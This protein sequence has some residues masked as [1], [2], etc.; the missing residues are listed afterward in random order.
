MGLTCT[1]P[2]AQQPHLLPRPRPRSFF[3]LYWSSFVIWTNSS[4][5]N[6]ASIGCGDDA[7]SGTTGGVHDTSIG[8]IEVSSTGGGLMLV[9]G[10]S[11]RTDVCLVP[12]VWAPPPLIRTPHNRVMDEKTLLDIK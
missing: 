4:S 3:Y 9:D 2:W 7:T 5:T 12:L 10:A 8:V 6:I 11:L 1:P